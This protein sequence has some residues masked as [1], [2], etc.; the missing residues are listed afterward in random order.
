MSTNTPLLKSDSSFNLEFAYV[1]L[2]NPNIDFLK[3]GC[4]EPKQTLRRIQTWYNTKSFPSK[5]YTNLS[6]QSYSSK[7]EY[8]EVFPNPAS[9]TLTLLSNQLTSQIINISIVDQIGRTVLEKQPN[10]E[11]NFL[12]T[13]IKIESLP[14]GIYFIK[15]NTQS[16]AIVKKFIKE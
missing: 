5:P 13:T 3:E 9:T 10:S 16:G 6:N 8:F 1:F 14:A 2:H 4:D 15:V 11:S 12:N 7:N